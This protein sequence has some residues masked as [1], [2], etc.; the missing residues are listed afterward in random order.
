MIDDGSDAKTDK[1][2]TIVGDIGSANMLVMASLGCSDG[3]NI[4]SNDGAKFIFETSLVFNSS[5]LSI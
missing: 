3:A 5:K 4:I 2:D 1:S